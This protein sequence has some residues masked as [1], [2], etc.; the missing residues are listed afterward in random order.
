MARSACPTLLETVFIMRHEQI[1]I[2]IQK[3]IQR[4]PLCHDQTLNNG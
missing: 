3:D 4:T 2:R 1:T